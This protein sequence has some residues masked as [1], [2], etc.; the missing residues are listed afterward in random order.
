[1]DRERLDRERQ[2]AAWMQ[3]T[4][5]GVSN[6]G[7]GPSD[8][9]GHDAERAARIARLFVEERCGELVAAIAAGE[10]GVNWRRKWER[11]KARVGEL[12]PWT[13]DVSEKVKEMKV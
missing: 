3:R 1:M 13:K 8:I 5:A 2:W 10:L 7:I 4:T 9:S 12:W 11:H 6:I